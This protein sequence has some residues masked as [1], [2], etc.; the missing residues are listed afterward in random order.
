LY[1]SAFIPCFSDRHLAYYLQC[2]KNTLR[3]LS[4]SSGGQH[5]LKLEYINTYPVPIPPLE[6]QI[7]IVSKVKKL[8]DISHELENKYTLSVM[9]SEQLERSVLQ[10]AFEVELEDYDIDSLETFLSQTRI[11]KRKTEEERANQKRKK[12]KEKRNMT[13]KILAKKPIINILK[14]SPNNK[15]TVE[16]VWQQSEHYELWEKD[17]Y[18]RFYKELESNRDKILVERSD[19]DMTITL[20]LID[21]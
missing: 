4:Y 19:N 8:L 3:A 14:D 10:E 20:T 6:E 18:E 13:Q 2:E 17:G 15:L 5:N 12:A 11:T 7:E 1:F 16:E 9:Y 21:K